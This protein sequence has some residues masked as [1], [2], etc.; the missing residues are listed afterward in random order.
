MGYRPKSAPGL[1]A[2]SL[3]LQGGY[4]DPSWLSG[5]L[6]LPPAG[7]WLDCRWVGTQKHWSGRVRTLPW[8]CPHPVSPWGSPALSST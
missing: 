3:E 6:V 7:P 4:L 1:G 2:L 5:P 8:L